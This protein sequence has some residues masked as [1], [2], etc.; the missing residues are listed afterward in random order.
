M[1][2]SVKLLA[3]R[4]HRKGIWSMDHIHSLL[5]MEDDLDEEGRKIGGDDM[6]TTPLGGTTATALLP[7]P[8]EVDLGLS[9]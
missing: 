4:N 8:T 9:V 1:V 2:S 3:I 7:H 6:Q 5:I